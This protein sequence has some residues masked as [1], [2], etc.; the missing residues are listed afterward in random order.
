SGHGLNA[1]NMLK[2]G[3]NLTNLMENP[4][5]NSFGVGSSR[6]LSL[7]QKGEWLN[8]E[9]L[10]RNTEKGSTDLFHGEEG[11][12]TTPLMIAVKENKLIIA[13][14]LID[15]GVNP[16]EHA[17][18]NRTALHYAASYGKDDM[19][20]LLLNRKADPSIA[21]GPKDQLPLH[22]ACARPTGAI[23]IV[24]A[25]LRAS[26]KDGR[27]V[28]DKDG[29]IPLFL[30]A[31]GG[32]VTVCKDLLAQQTLPQLKMQKQDNGDAVLHIACRRR[33]L[34]LVKILLD[35]GSP[36]D[37]QNF[38]GHTSLHIA[39]WEGDEHIV[40][41]LYQMKACP[42][43]PDKFERSP[44]HIAAE[45]GHTNIVEL[46]IEKFKASVSARTKDGSTLIHIAALCG[47][48]ETAMA[49]LK[50]GVPLHMPNK[51]GAICLHAAATRGHNAV[52]K[53][54]LQKGAPV[55]AKTKDG[56]TALHL[57]VEYG[58]PHVVQTLLGFGAQVE[59]KGGECQETSLHIAARTEEG[60]KCAEI[61]TK[62]GANVNATK[63]NGET[64][65]H[66]AARHCQF[67]MVETLLE[68]GADPTQ[69][70]KI[71]ETALHIAVRHCHLDVAR[72][73]LMFIYHQRSRLDAVM[74]VNQQNLEGE[75]C[76][77]MAAELTKRMI[78]SEFE[79]TD[80]IKILLQ[81]DGDI[82]VHTK[83]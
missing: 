80:I 4:S 75:T 36:I 11:S 76:V 58:K 13:E 64:A 15:L 66:I 8:L 55:D 47:H 34:D 70:S 72:A 10:L 68:E 25:L 23:T 74:L 28:T 22:L 18:D 2:N 1:S 65:I 51:S 21:G 46:L 54:L 5:P 7:C 31:E 9:Q 77:H 30:A 62:S 63:D 12:G 38:D 71:G 42:N 45:R 67:K 20:K 83:L 81:F 60:E 57:A 48:P 78:H 32:N 39:A 44:V 14:R 33:D 27:L 35:S 43:L 50:K 53:A 3:D 52:V 49:F 61:L 82:N 56:Y 6:I 24:Q 17:K 29:A 26:G 19:V 40:K 69:Q 16:N 73:I 41:Y 79:D 59:L 37:L